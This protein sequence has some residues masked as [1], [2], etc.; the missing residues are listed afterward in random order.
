MK[1]K[2]NVIGNVQKIEHNMVSY[3]YQKLTEGHIMKKEVI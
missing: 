3:F 2:K 1:Y